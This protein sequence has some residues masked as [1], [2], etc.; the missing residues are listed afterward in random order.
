MIKAI[1][2]LIAQI[3]IVIPFDATITSSDFDFSRDFH[4]QTGH[5]MGS[6]VLCCFMYADG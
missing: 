3:L 5:Q 4:Y 6:T 2:N 1:Y